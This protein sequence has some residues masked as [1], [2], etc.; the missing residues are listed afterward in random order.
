[1]QKYRIV[2]NVFRY[3]LKRVSRSYK[4]F[5]AL[6]LGVLV[7]T[8]FFASTN[9]AADILAR[10]ALTSTLDGVV[11][12]Y[13]VNSI[14]S[15]WTDAV[16]DEVESE[17]QDIDEVTEYTRT[18]M[19]GYNYNDS[20]DPSFIISGVEWDSDM[21]TGVTVT[22]GRDTLAMDEV[23]IVAGSENETNCCGRGNSLCSLSGE[24]R[25]G[26]G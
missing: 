21:V 10:D 5:A 20:L 25:R 13:T 8:T 2:R 12:D 1:M 15:N 19:F 22:S 4:L 9:V 16:F 26:T 17:V 6:T 14:Q 24:C 23:Y 11:Y 3:A 7:A 18:T